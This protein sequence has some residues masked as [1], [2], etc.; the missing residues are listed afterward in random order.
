VREQELRCACRALGISEL[1]FLGY[2]DGT[3]DS[4]DHHEIEEK[5]VR[6]IRELRPE[7]VLTFPPDGVSLHPDHM[8]MHRC[9]TAAFQHAGNAGLFPQHRQEGLAPYRPQKLYYVALRRRLLQEIGVDFPGHDDHITTEIDVS[10]YVDAKLRAIRCH[11]TQTDFPDI[12]EE[13]AHQYLSREHF[14]LAFPATSMGGLE[15][16]LF[17]NVTPQA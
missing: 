8:V 17:Q 5:I 1:R 6:A 16:D 4:Q 9:T 14:W 13:Q 15:T 11:R 12:S 7:V 2:C 10:Q 3:L